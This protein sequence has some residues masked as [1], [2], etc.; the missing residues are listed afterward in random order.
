[1]GSDAWHDTE[2]TNPAETAGSEPNVRFVEGVWANLK[3]QGL[4]ARSAGGI[5][6]EAAV[7]SRR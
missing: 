4:L 7:A 6:A 2:V 5:S 1:M 3:T